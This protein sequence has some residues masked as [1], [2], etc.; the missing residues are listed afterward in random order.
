MTT[1]NFL[2]TPRNT[3]TLQGNKFQF[4]LPDLPHVTFFCQMV[5]LPGAST[6][7][8]I[9]ETP[10]QTQYRHGDKMQYDPLV[11]TFLVDEDLGNWIEVYNW[12][13]GLTKPNGFQ[14]YNDQKKK[15]LYR[16][17]Q[18]IISTNSNIAN[19]KFTFKNCHPISLGP[20]TMTAMDDPN[21]TPTVDLTLQYDTYS[22]DKMN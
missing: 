2:N 17:C 19:Y 10:F 11:I 21:L 13:K 7:A 14:E 9:V 6:S 18:V 1:N 22:I 20:L 5:M 3:N 4:I 8:A 15:F 16:D 12:I